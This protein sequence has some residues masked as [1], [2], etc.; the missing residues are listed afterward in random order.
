MMIHIIGDNRIVR[1]KK[2]PDII[3]NNNLL[4]MMNNNEIINTNEDK[5]MMKQQNKG[6]IM[7]NL[8]E[9]GI[10]ITIIN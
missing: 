5:D 9:L 3:I 8:E 6:K 7:V 1:I 4:F 10:L 2:E